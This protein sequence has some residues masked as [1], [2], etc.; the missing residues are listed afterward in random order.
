MNK[1]RGVIIEG[2]ILAL[3][4]AAFGG[5]WTFYHIKVGALEGEVGAKQTA[6]D[7]M[8]KEKAGVLAKVAGLTVANTDF[9]KQ[10]AE[11]KASVVAIQKERNDKTAE[12]LAAT[13]SA[14][15]ASLGFKARIATILNQNA[16][17]DWCGTWSKLITDYTVMRQAKEPK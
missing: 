9:V 16:G 6:I 15:T 3:L 2:I 11:S 1:Q 7:T 8:A 10:I 5:L 17:I 14:A 12:A 4:V 13:R